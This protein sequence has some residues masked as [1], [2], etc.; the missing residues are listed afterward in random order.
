MVGCSRKKA[1]AASADGSAA[2]GKTTQAGLQR[3][4][5]TGQV[6]PSDLAQLG[7]QLFRAER[8]EAGGHEHRVGPHRTPQYFFDGCAHSLRRRGC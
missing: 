5:R 7:H 3:G 2:V 6:D 8:V 1:W 4:R